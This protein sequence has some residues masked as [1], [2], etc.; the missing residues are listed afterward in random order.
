MVQKITSWN[1]ILN[2][3]CNCLAQENVYYKYNGISV[4]NTTKGPQ[5]TSLVWEL[6]LSGAQ[7]TDAPTRLRGG[8]LPRYGITE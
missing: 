5:L 8:L 2:I 7:P 6:R 3:V 1:I 4:A